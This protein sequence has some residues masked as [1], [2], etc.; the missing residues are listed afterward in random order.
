MLFEEGEVYENLKEKSDKVFS[1]KNQN[2]NKKRIVELL[3]E[4]CNKEKIDII[5]VHHGGVSCNIV[6]I[7]LKKKLKNIKFVRYLHGS[8]DAYTFGNGENKIKD[9]IVKEVMRKALRISDLMIFISK[10]VEKTFVD[11]F[12]IN[13]KNRTVIYNGINKS[14]FENVIEK[15]ERNIIF[16]GRLTKVKGVDILLNAFR[17][18]C[19]KNSNVNLTIVG[20]GE[21]RKNL[22]K[23]AIDLGI[24]DKI[25]FTGRQTNVKDWLDKN[26]IFV[27]PSIWEEG[28]GISV[29]EAMARGCVPI[30][31][32]K[33]GLPEIIKNNENGYLIDSVDED[34]LADKILEALSLPDVQFNEL[35]K[36]A[37][38]KTKKFTLDATINKLQEEYSKILI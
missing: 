20:D 23:K 14:F 3:I 37:I 6:Y 35:R 21:E 29:V 19:N 33:G 30:T 22:E 38:E 10:A 7:M 26:A 36:N 32:K 28:F 12:K 24:S 9:I 13:N 2:R 25:S 18:V 11:N 17:K 34:K 31:F 16:V 5:T 4:Y 27:Y 8:F 1:L 15:S